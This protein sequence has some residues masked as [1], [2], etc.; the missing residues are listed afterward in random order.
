MLK[1]L[2]RL[3][4]RFGRY[5]IPNLTL[6]LIGGQATVLALTWF[7]Q[8]SIDVILLVPS[9]VLAGQ[10]WRLFTF[11][12]VPSV[13]DPIWALFAWYL[14]YLM[15]TAL[16]N[17]WSAFKY[18]VYLLIAYLA[19]VGTSFLTPDLPA[20]NLYLYS[21]VFLAFAFLHPNF[22]LY[23]FFL[24]PVK[25]KWLA[26]LTWIGYGASLLT[27]GMSTRLLILGA[28]GNFLL[29]FGADLVRRARSTQWRMEMRAREAAARSKPTHTCLVCG[30]NSTTHPDLDFRYCDE[31]EGQCGYCPE[32]IRDH[33]HVKRSEKP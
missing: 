23:L 10:F 3:D 32:H 21:S 8:L 11:L 5:A 30:K 24:L 13:S 33:E 14:F 19:T 29:F 2:D 26:L 6:F 15:G 1:L 12:L 28:V 17:Y 16:E 18:N 4:R 20:T 22:E 31:C 27:G 7:G 9:K 25:V